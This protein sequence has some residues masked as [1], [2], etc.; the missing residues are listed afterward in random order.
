MK[1]FAQHQLRSM[2]GRRT[3]TRVE[4]EQKHDSSQTSKKAVRSLF[5]LTDSLTALGPSFSTYLVNSCWGESTKSGIAENIQICHGI[6]FFPLF[7]FP[8]FV[9]IS[10]FW[11]ICQTWS[12]ALKCA[13]A[14]NADDSFLS[15]S[16]Q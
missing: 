11:G 5:P 6:Y 4:R 3:W 15:I 7:F 12:L 14:K 9:K 10:Q 13:A 2:L 1:N 8:Q 16:L